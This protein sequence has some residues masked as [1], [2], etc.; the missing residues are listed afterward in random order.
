[1]AKQLYL[2]LLMFSFLKR[3]VEELMRKKLVKDAAEKELQD[4][5]ELLASA[6]KDKPPKSSWMSEEKIW[7]RIESLEAYAIDACKN[8]EQR[9][10]AEMV[11]LLKTPSVS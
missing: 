7:S 9:K 11:I 1:M 2:L 4:F 10:T 8:D 6:K 5:V 3:K